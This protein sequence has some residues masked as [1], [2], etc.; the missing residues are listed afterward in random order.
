[1]AGARRLT[2]HLVVPGEG[3]LGDVRQSRREHR[4]VVG[5]RDV[6]DELCALGGEL[7]L[8]GAATRVGGEPL[9]GRAT[10]GEEILRELESQRPLILGAETDTAEIDASAATGLARLR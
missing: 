10:R 1:L 6:E 2:Q 4:V 3:R 9:T 8:G 7:D 5:L